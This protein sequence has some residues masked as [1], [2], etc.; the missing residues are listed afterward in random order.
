M[1]LPIGFG[2][3]GMEERREVVIGWFG[4]WGERGGETGVRFCEETVEMEGLTCIDKGRRV[5]HCG[6]SDGGDDG[7]SIHFM[8]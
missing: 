1:F 8:G 2:E 3:Y 5:S 7:G 4:V 6:G